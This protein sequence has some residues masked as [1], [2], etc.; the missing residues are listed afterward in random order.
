M[1]I[2]FLLNNF[3]LSDPF[4]YY[5]F[6]FAYHLINPWHQRNTTIW[7]TIYYML[8]CDYVLY[9]LPTDLN[10]QILPIVDYYSGKSPAQFLHTTV[11]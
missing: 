8:C 10:F 5:I 3:S 2:K 11:R 7:S 6:H 9:F 1:L 4:D